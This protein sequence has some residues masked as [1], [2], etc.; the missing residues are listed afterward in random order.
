MTVEGQ[1]FYKCDTVRWRRRRCQLSARVSLCSV[2]GY[3]DRGKPTPHQRYPTSRAHL[4]GLNSRGAGLK[5][6]LGLPR[7]LWFENESDVAGQ[8]SLAETLLA[9]TEVWGK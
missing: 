8:E 1:S 6:P 5:L 2:G 7:Q 4:V 3:A 9:T